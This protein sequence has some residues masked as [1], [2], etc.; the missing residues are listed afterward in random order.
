LHRY[1]N[2]KVQL[3]EMGTNDLSDDGSDEASFEIVLPCSADT[4]EGHQAYF[5]AELAA[6]RGQLASTQDKLSKHEKPLLKKTLELSALKKRRES[7]APVAAVE[8][9]P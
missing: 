1:Y 9:T 3:L 2:I 6:A 5:K 4:L 7:T 8:S